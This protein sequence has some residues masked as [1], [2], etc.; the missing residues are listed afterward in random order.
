MGKF[1]LP[2]ADLAPMDQSGPH[3]VDFAPL[4]ADLDRIRQNLSPLGPI[5][6]PSD[7]GGVLY[8]KNFYGLEL[9]KKHFGTIKKIRKKVIKTP[10]DPPPK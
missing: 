10:T 8:M 3:L 4:W 7:P 9:P 2:W 5:L 6:P 1:W